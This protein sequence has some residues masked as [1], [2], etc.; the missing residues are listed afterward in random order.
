MKESESQSLLKA[1]CR[2]IG[3]GG[4]MIRI[5]LFID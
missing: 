2:D 5:V 3:V 4:L 1:N